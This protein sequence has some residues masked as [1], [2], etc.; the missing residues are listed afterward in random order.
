MQSYEESEEWYKNITVQ[1]DKNAQF[2]LGLMYYWGK[3]VT[4][5]YKKAK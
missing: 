5:N 1:D 4:Q 3:G 2:Y